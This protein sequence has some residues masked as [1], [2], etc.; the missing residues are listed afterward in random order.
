MRIILLLLFSLSPF[1]FHSQDKAT[2]EIL[3]EGKLLYRMEKGSWYGTDHM[4]EHF[5]LKRDSIGGY[6]SYE[7]T[8]HKMNNHFS[9][10]R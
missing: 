2:E 10:L 1:L 8:D 7:T 5:Q 3:N 6:L 4:M 9:I